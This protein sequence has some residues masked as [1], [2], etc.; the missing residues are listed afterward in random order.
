MLSSRSNSRDRDTTK[1]SLIDLQMKRCR[2]IMGPCTLRY[3]FL[4]HLFT[5]IVLLSRQST[6][7]YDTLVFYFV[8][9][10]RCVV[11]IVRKIKIISSQ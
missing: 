11:Y 3:D 5:T 6:A 8:I 9:R 2:P 1:T 7:V 4:Y 10:H